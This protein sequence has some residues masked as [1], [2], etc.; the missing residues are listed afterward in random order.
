MKARELRLL[1][2]FAAVLS[3]IGASYG[4]TQVT[5]SNTSQ[6]NTGLN[7]FITQPTF[8]QPSSCP[9]DANAAYKNT[10]FAP[11]FW[12]LTAGD[13]GLSAYFCVDNQG[14]VVD[15]VQVTVTPGSTS[16]VLGSCP[17]SGGSLMNYVI[18][19]PTADNSIAAHTASTVP[20][21]INVC[22]GGNEALGAGPSFTI[23]VQ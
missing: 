14:S 22:A 4:V 16:M 6:I 17:N 11:L 19:V 5:L 18:S 2:V 23:T 7:I 3:I 13:Q 15:H 21:S 1:L 12:N 8:I 9:V 10:G 20:A